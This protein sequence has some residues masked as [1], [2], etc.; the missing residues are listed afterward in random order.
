[1]PESGEFGY[2]YGWMVGEIANR[3]VV[4]HPGRIEGFT[5]CNFYFPDDEIVVIVPSNQ[6]NVAAYSRGVQLE[7]MVFEEK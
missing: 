1:M 2:G 7:K 4:A 5:G 6:Q 3:R